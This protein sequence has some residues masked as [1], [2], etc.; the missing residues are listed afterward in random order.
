MS[1]QM[2]LFRR[3]RTSLAHSSPTRPEV[4]DR[5]S[6]APSPIRRV[7]QQGWAPVYLCDPCLATYMARL[8]EH[9]IRK[10]SQCRGRGTVTDAVWEGDHYENRRAPRFGTDGTGNT[11]WGWETAQVLVRGSWRTVRETC[12]K[13]RHSGWEERKGQAWVPFNKRTRQGIDHAATL[14]RRSLGL[15]VTRAD[16]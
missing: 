11:T 15:P 6:R 12:P 7:S 13:C 2:A 3:R 9:G 14:V 16:Q 4:C 10:C 5:C 1:D 8:E